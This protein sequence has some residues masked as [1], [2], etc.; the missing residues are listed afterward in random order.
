MSLDLPRLAA[1]AETGPGPSVL[2]RIA[3]EGVALAIWQRRLAPELRDWLDRLPAPA[4]PSF[5]QVLPALH[6][7]PAVLAACRAA[8]LGDGPG[9][10]LLADEI[11]QQARLAADAFACPLLRVRLSVAARRSCPKW[12]VDAVPVR[13]VSTLRG[14]G[15]EW[16]MVG[17]GG[18]PEE[19]RRMEPGEVGLFRGA[20]WPGDELAAILHR[21]PEPEPG[22]PRLVLV[23]D[24]AER[25]ELH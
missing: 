14:P 7:R 15:T 5:R 23:L 13:L 19:V 1:T 24:P 18:T 3:G 6:L 20:L 11:C 22:R 12:H 25:R 10:A 16:G 8:G 2:R 9:P 21:S 17:P 4:L